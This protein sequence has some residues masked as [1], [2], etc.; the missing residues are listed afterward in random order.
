[1]ASRLPT[2]PRYLPAIS[3][4][5]LGRAAHHALEPKLAA[6]A[7]HGFR[8]I[9]L[10]YED[11]EY[12]ARSLPASRPASPPGTSFP[13]SS[14][15]EEAQLAAASYVGSLCQRHGLHLLCLQPFMHY[16]GLTCPAEHEKRIEKIKFWFL[17][18]KRLDTDLIQIPSNFLPPS[19]CTGDRARIVADLQEVADM[20]LQQQPVIRFAYEALCWGTHVDFWEQAW[21][22]VKAVDRVNFGTCLDTFNI[23]GRVWADPQA[24]DGRVQ[25]ADEALRASLV[26]MRTEV[27]V[28][29][30]FYVEVEDAERMRTPLREGHE[31]WVDEQKA[32]MSWSRNARLFPF[33][34]ESR[35]GYLPVL[36]ILSVITDQ[37]GYTGYVSFEYFSRTMNECG[38]HVPE[39]HASR[40][41][42]SWGKLVEYM[43][44]NEQKVGKTSKKEGAVQVDAIELGTWAGGVELDGTR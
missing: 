41:E 31:W 22:V 18:A 29:K 8:A 20:G 9:E 38:E 44:W 7:A 36:D 5:S 28:K 11:L 19:Q 37:V 1:M 33:E 32:R 15:W 39:E 25:G 6:A 43:G 2:P 35:G 27:D 42:V 24:E 26:R 34:T 12:V 17:L 4:M 21:D 40:A 16:D 3:S 30:L 13:S 23:A 14:S 10:F